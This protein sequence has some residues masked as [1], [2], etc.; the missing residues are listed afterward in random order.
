MTP[1]KATNLGKNKG[2]ILSLSPNPSQPPEVGWWDREGERRCTAKVAALLLLLSLPFSRS[3]TTHTKITSFSLF[4]K[5]LED[6]VGCKGCLPPSSL[7]LPWGILL[8]TTIGGTTPVCLV[9]SNRQLL[10][11][12]AVKIHISAAQFYQKISGRIVHKP[13]LRP[14]L[15]CF[16]PSGDGSYE[17]QIKTCRL[18]LR[19]L[20]LLYLDVVASASRV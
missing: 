1:T 3:P 9:L 10:P 17:W 11:L 5:N 16:S 18:D 6:S 20:S 12:Q 4:Q 7:A 13:S 15:P 2:E 19:K 14:L 8:W